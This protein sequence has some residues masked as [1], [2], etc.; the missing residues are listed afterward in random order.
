MIYFDGVHLWS[1][2]L[3]QLHNYAITSLKMKREWFQFHYKHPHYDVLAGWR[4]KFVTNDVNVRKIL[5]KEMVLLQNLNPFTVRS[6]CLNNPFAALMLNGKIETRS[7]PTNV[8]GTT[9][10]YSAKKPYQDYE[11]RFITG[12]NQNLFNSIQCRLEAN[13]YR[14][15]DG[16]AIAIA[17]L[18]GCRP[19][20]KKD[21]DKCFVEYREGLYCW[22][23]DH[24]YAVDPIPYALENEQGKTTSL[25][26]QGWSFV[27]PKF[28]S[29]IKLLH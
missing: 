24:V 8:R 3:K 26:K 18:V 13:T 27:P 10:I 6:L 17:E 23:F 5:S 11:V 2:D 16:C 19:M 25:G 28:L 1:P 9:L 22:I 14:D 7:R 12:A 21:E 20:E 15:K 29:K 4:K